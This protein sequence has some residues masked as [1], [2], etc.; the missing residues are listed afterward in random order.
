MKRKFKQLI[1][2]IDVPTANP[3][4]HLIKEKAAPYVPIASL[5]VNPEAAGE[6]KERQEALAHL[7][8][9]APDM[10]EALRHIANED[11]TKGGK[12][13]HQ[14]SDLAKVTL[15]RADGKK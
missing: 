11:V 2:C 5:P 6:V 15:D 7:F 3:P 14:F 1:A 9:A 12:L 10:Y 4:G 13:A 8:A